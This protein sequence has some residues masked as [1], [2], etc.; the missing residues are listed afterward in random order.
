LLD[1]KIGGEL[2]DRMMERGRF[3]EEYTRYIL[4]QIGSAV[5]YLHRKNIVHR[6]LKPENMLFD[7]RTGLSRICLADF[8]FAKIVS[9]GESLNTPCGTPAYVAPEIVNSESYKKTV[10]MWSLGVVM[11]TLLSGFPPFYSE[12]DQCLLDMIAEGNFTFPKQAWENI[13]EEAR[14]LV[15]RLLEKDP[16]KRCTAEQFLEHQWTQATSGNQPFD[17]ENNHLPKHLTVALERV[18]KK[19]E[20]KHALNRAVAVQREGTFL[21]SASESTLWKRRQDTKHSQV[22]SL[23]TK[24]DRKLLLQQENNSQLSKPEKDTNNAILPTTTSSSTT[25]SASDVSNA[26]NDND[27]S[28]HLTRSADS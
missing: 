4:R 25:T 22:S 13:S 17:I 5:A 2:F 28:F 23:E 21:R 3:S 14:D 6:D 11:Y 27:S 15:S 1:R 19:E 8:G 12:D 16:S 20:I 10:D 7:D 26:S 18:P 24:G 9:E